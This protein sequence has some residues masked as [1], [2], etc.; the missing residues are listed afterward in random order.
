M[1]LPDELI[2]SIFLYLDYKTIYKLYLNDIFINFNY[3]KVN[4]LFNKIYNKISGKY[5]LEFNKMIIPYDILNKFGKFNTYNNINTYNNNTSNKISQVI[6]FYEILIGYDTYNNNSLLSNLIGNVITSKTSSASR[7]NSIVKFLN[8]Y[9]LNIIYF[10]DLDINFIYYLRSLIVLKIYYYNSNI[11]PGLNKLI[12]LKML[13]VTHSLTEIPK[14]NSLTNLKK[15]DLSNNSITKMERL[16]KLINLEEL[17]LSYNKIQKI[18]GINNLKNLLILYLYYNN[19]TDISQLID[20]QNIK[21]LILNDNNIKSISVCMNLS[22]LKSLDINNNNFDTKDN[23]FIL[24]IR[25][26]RSIKNIIIFFICLLIKLYLD[27]KILYKL[28][29]LIKLCH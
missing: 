16:D 26:L 28:Y 10:H 1:N 15:L 9:E 2:L 22:K 18:E 8:I 3:S 4:L 17:N 27:Y 5:G 29:L 21:A 6:C 24:T 12:N 25:H 14:L 13:H 20:N 11:I 19:I 7:T 23:S